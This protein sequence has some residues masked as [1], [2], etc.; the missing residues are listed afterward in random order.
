MSVPVRPQSNADGLVPPL[1][2]QYLW[3]EGTGAEIPSW[4][5]RGLSADLLKLEVGLWTFAQ[6]EGVEP[7]NNPAERALRPAV[8]WRK[9]CFGSDRKV[10]VTQCDA[11]SVAQSYTAL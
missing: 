3:T 1:V 2:V 7:T 9:G 4:Q 10:E 8:L 11:L 6:V 5:V